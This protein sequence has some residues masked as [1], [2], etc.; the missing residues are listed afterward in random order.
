MSTVVDISGLRVKVCKRIK[1]Y[2]YHNKEFHLDEHF[3]R[4][5]PTIVFLICFI[6]R[7]NHSYWERHNVLKRQY[8]KLF[9]IKSNKYE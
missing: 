8:L 3:D 6:D 2:Y 9:G 4:Q 5:A 7:L 1:R